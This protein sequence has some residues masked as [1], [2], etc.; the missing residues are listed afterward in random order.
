M[1]SVGDLGEGPNSLFLSLLVYLCIPGQGPDT[2]VKSPLP[3]YLTL[4]SGGESCL[5]AKVFTVFSHTEQQL[6]LVPSPEP[7]AM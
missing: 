2:M 4:P 7:E 1:Q 5:C 3:L 6:H